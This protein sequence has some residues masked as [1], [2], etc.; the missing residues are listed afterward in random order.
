M[1]TS[2]LI[3]I[4]VNAPVFKVSYNMK[5]CANKRDSWI[6]AH[7]RDRRNDIK[8]Q[9]L[10]KGH[11]PLNT[12]SC[13]FMDLEMDISSMM[14]DDEVTNNMLGLRAT[15]WDHVDWL[16]AMDKDISSVARSVASDNW[17]GTFLCPWLS[18][19]MFSFSRTWFNNY[20]LMELTG[21][22]VHCTGEIG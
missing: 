7:S 11:I 20:Y 5:S 16:A 13:I 19:Y 6:V 15:I 4:H 10:R 8:G 22:T 2:A 18:Q 21:V 14:H 3:D 12:N 1:C 17:A 9:F